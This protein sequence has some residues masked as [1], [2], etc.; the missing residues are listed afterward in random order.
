MR[1]GRSQPKPSGKGRSAETK[2]GIG[3]I[4]GKT[5]TKVCKD[6]GKEFTISKFQPYIVWCKDC[7]KGKVYTGTKKQKKVEKQTMKSHGFKCKECE[8]V[9]EYGHMGLFTCKKCKT[10]YWVYSDGWYRTFQA[11]YKM[12]YKGDFAGNVGEIDQPSIKEA[13]EAYNAK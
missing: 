11:P 13:I 7:R 9:L 5:V 8:E 10:Q 12:Y 1:L 2:F 4:M 6:C 3:A